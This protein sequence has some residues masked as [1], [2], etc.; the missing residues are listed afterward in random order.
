MLC[1]RSAG[2]SHLA[3]ISL[4]MPVL[5]TVLTMSMHVYVCV[6]VC[7]QEESLAL[8]VDEQTASPYQLRTTLSLDCRV[9]QMQLTNSKTSQPAPTSRPQGHRPS[10]SRVSIDMSDTSNTTTTVT[11][12][13]ASAY[14]LRLAAQLYKVTRSMQ[15]DVRQAS[16]S[17]P[18]GDLFHVG[19]LS[20]RAQT[21]AAGVITSPGAKPSTAAHD[22]ASS[23]A[24]SVSLV[25]SPQDGHAD[26]EAA[27]HIA[28]SF[29]TWQPEAIAAVSTFFTPQRELELEALQV[30]T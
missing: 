5:A 8:G 23:S 24:L 25:Q 20:S 15:V 18:H 21:V 6:C 16:I 12:A 28:P 27:V 19:G 14:S 1:Y 13:C 29:V 10:L 26:I 22:V 17:C 9:M 11:I 7:G 4:C 2:L 30:R 3:A